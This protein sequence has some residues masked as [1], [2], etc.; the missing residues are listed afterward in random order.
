[1]ENLGKLSTEGFTD[2]NRLFCWILPDV[3][4]CF[5]TC[6]W[7]MACPHLS[8]EDTLHTH[9]WL[10]L[11]QWSCFIVF[12]CVCVCEWGWGVGGGGCYFC[13]LLWLE[14]ILFFGY[15]ICPGRNRL[16]FVGQVAMSIQVFF[17]DVYFLVTLGTCGCNFHSSIHHSVCEP[18]FILCL[19]RNG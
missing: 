1:M 12:L 18:C 10:C 16:V 9:S 4:I 8:V 19:Y 13:F 2:V 6:W 17:G 14:P 5:K 7:Y 11:L 15:H 3:I